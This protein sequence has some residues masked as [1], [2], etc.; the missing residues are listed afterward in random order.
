VAK[1]STLKQPTFIVYGDSE[2]WLRVSSILDQQTWPDWSNRIL[3]PSLADDGLGDGEASLISACF[4]CEF[5]WFTLCGC[6]CLD[7]FTYQSNLELFVSS[8]FAFCWNN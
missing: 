1:Y 6:W 4:P 2:A 7:L 3:L 8:C 5:N